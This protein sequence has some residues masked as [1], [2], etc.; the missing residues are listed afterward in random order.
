[1]SGGVESF[2][3]DKNPAG[4]IQRCEQR[5]NN[6][7]TSGMNQFEGDVLLTEADNTCVHQVF[8]FLM[9]VG[10]PQNG[11]T[12]NEHSSNLLLTQ[13]FGTWLHVNT[14]HD[15]NAKTADIYLDCVHRLTMPELPPAASAGWYDKY[16]LYGIQSK[17]PVGAVSKVQW[18]NIHYYRK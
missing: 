7:Y 12:L 13:A 1:V 15:T 14:I 6:D 5:V 11:G 9:L 8:E 18:K 10:Y 16:G 17:P 3:M 4:V 2:E